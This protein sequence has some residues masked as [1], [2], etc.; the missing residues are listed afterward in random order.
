MRKNPSQRIG[1]SPKFVLPL[2]VAALVACVQ[3]PATAH[4]QSVNWTEWNANQMW[5]AYNSAFYTAGAK[6]GQMYSITAGSGTTTGFWEEAEEIEMAEDAHDWAVRNNNL[7]SSSAIATQIDNL[8]TGFKDSFTGTNP[9]WR[10][11]NYDDDI[12]WATMAFARAYQITGNSS[13]L[14]D[15]ESAFNYVWT[16]GQ[17]NGKTDGSW[18]LSQIQ[19]QQ[20]MYANVNFSFVIAGYLLYQLSGNV[21]YKNE[22]DAI[23]TWAKQWLYV[24]NHLPAQNGSGN[25][26]SMIYNYNNSEFTAGDLQIRDVMYNYGIAIH[27]AD[28]EN[29]L[30]VAQTVANWMMYNVGADPNSATTVPYAGTYAGYN[31][32]PDYG[33]GT[34]NGSNDCGYNGIGMR[35]FGVSLR[36]G[37]LT[38]PDALPFAQANLQSAWNNRGSDNLEWC[39]WTTTPSGT[40]YS[41]GD[42]SALAGMFDIPAPVRMIQGTGVVNGSATSV[43]VSFADPTSAGDLLVVTLA[44]DSGCTF[45]AP[46]GWVFVTSLNGTVVKGSMW[47]YPNC[48]A[49]VSSATFTCTSSTYSRAVASE[50]AGLTTLDAKGNA[51]PGSGTTS[52]V[53]NSTNTTATSEVAFSQFIPYFP[54]AQKI[55]C[56]PGSNWVNLA[57]NN[58]T[59]VHDHVTADYHFIVNGPGTSV[60][61]TE[62]SSVSANEWVDMIAIFKP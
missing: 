62:T 19:G 20:R 26:C 7:I 56:T 14:S 54:T 43:T 46:T 24:Y 10:W 8:C 34:N 31:I 38:N 55:T 28:L 6:G 44:G 30:T 2:L 45:S 33:A 39:G 57:N 5:T 12:I 3:L 47:Y 27:A 41:W 61:E 52:T 35:G 25:I 32:L 37:V 18:G 36:D 17:V 29:D 50:W 60:G 40:E 59:S 58:S 16:H 22:A 51:A 4:A 11:D 1:L 15:A 48:P 21:T 53:T 9:W 42:S 13:R 49:G 23:Y